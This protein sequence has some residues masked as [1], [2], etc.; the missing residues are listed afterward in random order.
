MSSGKW[1]LRPC[2]YK[3]RIAHKE[4]KMFGYSMKERE[5]DGFTT[6]ELY[7]IP[8]SEDN[9]RYVEEAMLEFFYPQNP[10]F[11]EKIEIRDGY[12]LYARSDMK[13]PCTEDSN[14]QGVFYYKYIARG[15]LP[16]PAVI[17]VTEKTHNFDRDRSRDILSQ[18]TIV[19]AVYKM[20]EKLSPQASYWMLTQMKKQWCDLPVFEKDR[21]ADLNTWYYVICQLVRNICTEYK[22]VDRFVQE[23][24]MEKYVYIER[25]GSDNGKNRVLRE[26]DKWFEQQNR[27][28]NR[29]SRINPVFRLLGV[30]S[31][32]QE[33][34]EKRDTL[35]RELNKK[36]Q[37]R[38][39]LIR[40]CAG[41]VFPV[42]NHEEYLPKLLVRTD[43]EKK[44]RSCPH[45]GILPYAEATTSRSFSGEDNKRHIRYRVQEVIMNE[46]DLAETADFQK[47]LLKYLC[48]C[49]YMYGT[50][51]SEHSN[52]MLT[53][54]GSMLYR[55]RD[56]VVEYE[57][58]WN[59][60]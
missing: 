47:V 25:L 37:E 60:T 19:G 46:E 39:E 43:M 51:R 58:R 49:T 17:H 42:L 27:N 40:A 8:A 23:Y 12:S 32:L 13:I 33:Y 29:R 11:A 31:I 53:Y 15:R 4:I 50:E 21:Y 20:V 45:Y 7:G 36:E 38:G 44:G 41:K 3:E 14:I 56:S 16:F 54:I 9:I 22:W 35:Y 55:S 30:S 24:P 5:D 34:I 2:E 57:E 10:L 48:A 28:G 18:A 26:A 6:L 59:K 52:G 1:E